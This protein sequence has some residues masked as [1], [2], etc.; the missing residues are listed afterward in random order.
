LKQTISE[1][2][3]KIKLL[4]T[5][6][7]HLSTVIVANEKRMV[8]KE[9]KEHYKLML[10]YDSQS[11]FKLV[12]RSKDSW[13]RSFERI[14][15]SHHCIFFKDAVPISITF[16]EQV[17]DE[18]IKINIAMIGNLIEINSRDQI[19][20]IVKQIEYVLKYLNEDEAFEKGL[21]EKY[22]EELGNLRTTSTI[23][24]YP[25]VLKK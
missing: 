5:N 3:E 14:K 10:Y 2:Q 16:C 8:L 18:P 25:I 15:D 13:T 17:K 6:N 7:T 4:D 9:Y 12:R 19:T 11:V 22:K 21:E 23:S 1:Q 20:Q 24:L